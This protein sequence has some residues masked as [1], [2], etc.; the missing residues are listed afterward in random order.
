MHQVGP[1][2]ARHDGAVDAVVLS[3]SF[4]FLR[5]ELVTKLNI[6]GPTFLPVIFIFVCRIQVCVRGRRMAIE[7]RASGLHN[8]F[9]HCEGKR[10]WKIL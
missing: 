2:H 10:F 1:Y 4:F 3:A 5:F 9:T 6:K 8:R 7:T